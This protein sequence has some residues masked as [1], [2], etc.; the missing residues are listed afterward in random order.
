MELLLIYLFIALGFSFLCSMLEATLLSISPSF[1]GAKVKEGKKYGNRL[2]KLK[3]DVDKPLAAILTLNTFAH[4]LGAAGVGA[5]A[6]LIWGSEYISIISVILTI[7]ILVLSEIIPKT[8]GAVHWRRLAGFT[9]Y[10]LNLF[11]ISLYPFVVV[12]RTIT[13]LLKRKKERKVEREDVEAISE[14]GFQEGVIGKDESEII[15]NLLRLNKLNAEDIMTPRIVVLAADEDELF[16][17]FYKENPKIEFS[18]IPVYSGS[19]DNITGFILKDE[20][21]ENII[22]GNGEKKLKEI[23]RE[24]SIVYEGLPV[25]KLFESL[26]K[27]NKHISAVVNEFGGIEGVVTIEDII[28][29]LLGIEIMD[30]MDNIEDLQKMA[31]EK[32]KKKK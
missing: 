1:I 30:E 3:E 26:I 18:R 20:L 22:M 29:T 31:K 17:S 28:E 23:K 14:I 27:Q 8:L 21:L 10:I 15:R 12:S 32:W 24:I 11:I 9:S 4:T 6:Q 7:V 13:K 19:I 16:S 5:Q 2:Q 25:L